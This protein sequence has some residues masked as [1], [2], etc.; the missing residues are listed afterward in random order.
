MRQEFYDI[1]HGGLVLSAV[2]TSFFP[3]AAG[4]FLLLA[5]VYL[6]TDDVAGEHERG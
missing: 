6:L 2:A 5:V 4:A 3:E 1:L